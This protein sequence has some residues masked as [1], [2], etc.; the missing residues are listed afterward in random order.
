MP[1]IRTIITVAAV[2]FCFALGIILTGPAVSAEAQV[3]AS[4][5]VEKAFN[6][7]KKKQDLDKQ[8][9]AELQQLQSKLELRQTHP[10]L[11]K[12]EFDELAALKAKEK[13]TDAEKKRIETMEAMSTQKEKDLQALRQKTTPTDEEK[14]SMAALQEVAKQTET[15]LRDSAKQAD[16]EWQ[17][18]RY[19]L[20]KQVME[21]VQAAVAAVAKQKNITMVFNKSAGETVLV[22]YSSNDIT[23]DVIAR[24]NKG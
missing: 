24:L 11:T 10:L 4:V 16:T 6:D 12:A 8:V 2:A 20:S 19:E 3:F 23:A 5:D 22:V 13:P 21:D 9:M 7:Y 1:R 14:A 17:A 18:K 15:E